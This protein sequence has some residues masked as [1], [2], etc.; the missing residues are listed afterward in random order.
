MD[1]GAGPL[2]RTGRVARPAPARPA[3]DLQNLPDPA[4]TAPGARASGEMGERMGAG[5]GK[6]VQREADGAL[7]VRFTCFDTVVDLR[8]YPDAA[9][10][11]AE[12]ADGAARA[13]DACVE[14]C[15]RFE[16]LLSRT[17]PPTDNSRAQAAAPEPVPV[18]RETAELVGA[19]RA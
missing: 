11:C 19:A 8:V 2:V 9:P 18:A 5:S 4:G 16:R 14:R 1:D 12:G 3:G 15:R 17:D 13:L 10:G 6:R 7:A